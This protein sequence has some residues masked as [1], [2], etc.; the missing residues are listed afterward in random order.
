[1]ARHGAAVK[2]MAAITSTPQQHH[3]Q[4]EEEGG[5]DCHGRAGYG[6]FQGDKEMHNWCQEVQPDEV[7]NAQVCASHAAYQRQDELRPHQSFQHVYP[8]FYEDI[9]IKGIVVFKKAVNR[10]RNVQSLQHEL[11]ELL[12][13]YQHQEPCRLHE[14]RD[15]S[16]ESPN[17]WLSLAT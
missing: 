4:E 13:G 8:N 6:R 7:Q 3:E 10:R 1:M 11:S 5:Q 9:N 2:T 14:G 12:R 17:S 16:P 15:P